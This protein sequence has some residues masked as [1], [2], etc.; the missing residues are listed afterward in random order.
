MGL[1]KSKPAVAEARPLATPLLKDVDEPIVNT[2]RQ[3]QAAHDENLAEHQR[4][5]GMSEKEIE[6]SRQIRVRRMGWRE[7]PDLNGG[8]LVH[9][10]KRKFTKK[11]NRKKSKKKKRK[12]KK[13]RK[14][15][16]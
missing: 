7:G 10:K 2:E 8:G 4:G 13:T 12:S 16:S 6:K 9:R 11:S 5:T 1:G 3:R 14:R 15:R